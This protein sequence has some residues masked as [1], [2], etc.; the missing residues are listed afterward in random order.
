MA[1]PPVPLAVSLSRTAGAGAL[2][3]RAGDWVGVDVEALRPVEPAGLAEVV[4]TA[5]E[6]AHV[7]AMPPGAA[8]DAAFHRAWTRKEA[9]VKAVGL[10]LLGME[11]NT[12]DVSPAQDGPVRVVHR[13]RGE[14]TRWQVTDVDFGDRWAASL[15]RPETS[16]LGPV[17]IHA[18]A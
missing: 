15:A 13:Y 5:S 6:G 2:A 11:L 17:H 4:L 18:P 8:R 12:L 16:L 9:V 3:V 1:D 10:G 7:L 14:E